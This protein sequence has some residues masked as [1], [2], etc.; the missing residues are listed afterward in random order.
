MKHLLRA[1][2]QSLCSMLS[3]PI[4]IEEAAIRMDKALASGDAPTIVNT[5]YLLESELGPAFVDKMAQYRLNAL[6]PGS[7][8]FESLAKFTQSLAQHNLNM[9][10]P[11]VIETNSIS[12]LSLVDWVH[13][14][15]TLAAEQAK[16]LYHNPAARAV[17]IE[18]KTLIKKATPALFC[19]N[20][21]PVKQFGGWK[22]WIFGLP[23]AYLPNVFVTRYLV[24]SIPAASGIISLIVFAA[25]VAISLLTLLNFAGL[26]A[27]AL[28]RIPMLIQFLGMYFVTG[29]ALAT[30]ANSAIQQEQEGCLRDTLPSNWEQ[31]ISHNDKGSKYFRS[32]LS[33]FCAQL[34]N[35]HI[36][37]NTLQISNT[38]PQEMFNVM[39]QATGKPGSYHDHHEQRYNLEEIVRCIQASHAPEQ[40]HVQQELLHTLNDAFKPAEEPI[41]L[42][43]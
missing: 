35:N 3:Q 15:D 42:R 10:Q 40:L 23:A 7:D 9:G 28:K 14:H 20:M 13:I 34:T 16:R 32:V 18:F 25:S 39:L 24:G 21:A 11:L 30:W 29:T 26:E 31:A 2:Q 22:R 37:V 33:Y 36:D 43:I 17:P 6:P 38:S 1:V 19:N 4:S 41:Q 5:Y 12:A 8:K 27:P